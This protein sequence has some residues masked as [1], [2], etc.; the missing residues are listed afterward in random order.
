MAEIDIQEKRG[1]PMW[2]W[3]LGIVALLVL[4]G[5]IWALMANRDD[6]DD[7]RMQ[8]DTV[9]TAPGTPTSELDRADDTV[10]AYVVFS[11]TPAKAAPY[12]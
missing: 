3:I 10:L 2:V 8:R 1:Q 4:A 9:P 6:R 11:E 5:V 12:L 7:A